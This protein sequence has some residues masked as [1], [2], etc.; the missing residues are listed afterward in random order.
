MV[1][2]AQPPLQSA[3]LPHHISQRRSRHSLFG[4]D[5][6]E[7]TVLV[8]L[9]SMKQ[10][11]GI[12]AITA[13]HRRDALPRFHVPAHHGELSTPLQRR[14]PILAKQYEICPSSPVYF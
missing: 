4:A 14:A 2:L 9:V 3:D 10:L 6:R 11:I 5:R 13:G 1:L 12:D 7:V 8:N